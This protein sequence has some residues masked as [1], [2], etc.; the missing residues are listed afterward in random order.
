MRENFHL[1]YQVLPDVILSEERMGWDPTTDG[2]IHQ[3]VD[4]GV[5]QLHHTALLWD[6]VRP[7]H[8]LVIIT[9]LLVIEIIAWWL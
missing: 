1:E 6:L 8:T 3:V 2:K 5:Q 9:L 4:G 7:E